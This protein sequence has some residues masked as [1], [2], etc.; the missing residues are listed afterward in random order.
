MRQPSSK[1][2][3]LLNIQEEDGAAHFKGVVPIR[4]SEGRPALFCVRGGASFRPLAKRLRPDQPFLG[5]DLPQQV[6]EQ[7]PKPYRIED[8]A[9]A[10]IQIMQAVSRK[11]PTVWLVF[12]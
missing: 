5:L 3:R 8:L 6:L 2:A 9:A 11:G 7:L 10:F 4:Q 12:A 1:L